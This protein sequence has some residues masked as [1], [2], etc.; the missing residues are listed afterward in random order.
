VLR[1]ICERV[2]NAVLVLFVIV[3]LTFFLVQLIPGNAAQTILGIGA[4][5]QQLAVVTRQLGLD[6]PVGAR[7][8]TFWSDTL[9]GNFGHSLITG[10]S[11]KTSIANALPITLSL[12]IS[13]TIVIGVLGIAL[14]VVSAVR[15]GWIDKFVRGGSSLGMAFPNY[16]L[17]VLLVILFSIKI[18]IFPATGYTPIWVSPEQWASGMVLPVTAIGLAGIASI[19]RQTRSAMLETLGKD[20]VRSLRAQGIRTRSIIYKHALRNASI[21]IVTNIGFQFI[22]VLGGS[23]LIEQVFALPGIGQ[24]V[25]TAVGQHDLPTVQGAVIVMAGIVVIINLIVDILYLILNPKTR[26]S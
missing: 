1:Y 12:A 23:V 5:K 22:G 24:L 20:Y 21:P 9:R 7:F 13:A 2:L 4:T 19:S 16:W 11:V 14:G 6:R 25:L 3:S 18:K 17:A 8:L 15:G 26:R 10:E